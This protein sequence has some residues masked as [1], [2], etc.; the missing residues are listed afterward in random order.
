MTDRET[1]YELH[2]L[3]MKAFTSLDNKFQGKDP[4]RSRYAQHHIDYVR[5]T[6]AV[7]LD[8][9]EDGLAELAED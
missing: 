7:V 1:L 3:L 6:L 5:D 9:L 2:E 8:G 4:Q